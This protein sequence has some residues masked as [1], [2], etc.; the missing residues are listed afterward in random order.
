MSRVIAVCGKGGTGKTTVAS[1]MVRAL[2]NS[3]QGPILAVDADPNANLGPM[4]GIEAEETVGGVLEEFH[5]KRMEIPQGMS[6]QAFLELRLNQA[7]AETKGVDLVTMGRPEGPG[8]YCSANAVLRDVLERLVENY[9]FAV[10]DNEAGMEHLS[11]RTANRIDMLLMISDPSMKGL[12]TIKG[13]F[14][15]VAELGLPVME[16]Y[17]VMARTKDGLDQRLKE[18]VDSLPVPLLA[19][20]PEDP[21]VM[22][23]DL[24]MK[25]FLEL[26]DS[27]AAVKA[28][29]A[30]IERIEKLA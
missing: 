1:L 25:S 4:L 24:A 3:G 13:L 2:L 28:C 20:V 21:E 8:C 5:E 7:V 18:Y 30:I 29:Q 16:K 14:E 23:C 11:R 6:K 27:S 12:R 26:P 15:L 9:R 22:E 10:I 17:A 19:S